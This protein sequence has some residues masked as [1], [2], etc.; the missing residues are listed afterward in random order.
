MTTTATATAPDLIVLQHIITATKLPPLAI[1]HTI[2]LLLDGATVPFIARYRKEQTTGLD[3]VQ[4]QT[5]SE[6][7]KYFTELEERKGTV[8]NSI[9][10][11][12]KLTAELEK[13]IINCTSKQTLED[14]YLPYKPKRRTK[15][16]IARE[17]GLQPLA[18]LIQEQQAVGTPEELCTPFLDPAKEIN[19]IEEALQGAMEIIAE[20]IA[21]T[22]VYREWFRQYLTTKSAL[23]AQALPEWQGKKSKYETYY[24]YNEPLSKAPSHRVLAVRRGA[25]E[26]VL[27]RELVYDKDFVLEYLHGKIVTNKRFVFFA[28]LAKAIHLAQIKLQVSLSTEVFVNKLAEAETE[29]ISVFSRNLRN[30]LLAAPAGH[31]VIMGIDPGFRTGCKLVIIDQTGVFREYTAIFPHPPQD[32]LGEAEKTVITLLKKYSVE[33]ISIGNGTASKETTIFIKTILK[34]HNLKIPQIVVNEAGASVYSASEKAREEFPELDVTVR[35]AISIARRLQDPLAELVKIDPQA[36]GVGQYQH[37][38]NQTQLK[39]S[40]TQTVESC[41][42]HVGVELNTASAELLAYVSG[43]NKTIA[44]NI[45]KYRTEK[46]AFTTRQELLNVTSLGEKAFQQCAGFLKIRNSKNPLDNSTIHPESYALVERMAQTLKLPTEKLLGNSAAL[47]QIKPQDFYTENIGQL[48]LQDILKELHKP[49][50]DPRED[51]SA[52]EFSETINELSDLKPELTLN[53]VVTNVANFGAF[54]D[55]G[56]HQDGLIHISKLSNSFVKDPHTIVAVGDK[57][58]VKVLNVDI[59]L[60]RI[61]LELIKKV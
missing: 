18:E 43:L 15:A 47:K 53:G 59:E 45:I 39:N 54:V 37:D 50:L 19:T 7:L 23:V 34:K 46:G 26:E 38:V 12:N 56:V 13:E 32:E 24:N 44:K 55:I 41:V 33:L 9:K 1:R 28:E 31:K 3:E 4:I 29:A 27:S 17:R 8:L 48:T 42:N 49:G 58:Q 5:I 40:L 36:I 2:E 20:E 6:K 16:M 10:E 57:V 30:L 21:E 52:F 11:Q 51:F 35:G 60:K 22:S 14:L 25:Q 61:S